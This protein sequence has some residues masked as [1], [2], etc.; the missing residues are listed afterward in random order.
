MQKVN[1]TSN[2]RS[3]RDVAHTVV[4]AQK[5]ISRMSLAKDLWPSEHAMIKAGIMSENGGFLVTDWLEIT[6]TLTNMK[7]SAAECFRS[8]DRRKELR[9]LG[10]LIQLQQPANI[11]L[12]ELKKIDNQ[13][14]AVFDAVVNDVF[15]AAEY[16]GNVFSGETCS[17]IW[18]VKNLK[19][20]VTDKERNL[21]RLM[22]ETSQATFGFSVEEISLDDGSA[23]LTEKLK[24][25]EK[26][27]GQVNGLQMQVLKL[28]SELFEILD[29]Q[30]RR[31]SND[32]TT[33]SLLPA[34]PAGSAPIHLCIMMNLK[35]T[36]IKIIERYYNSPEL[37]SCPVLNDLDAWR[38]KKAQN[39]WE[40]GLYTGESALH[41]AIVQEDADLVRY[42]LESGISLASRATGLFF[43]PK[44]VPRRVSGA[45]RSEPCPAGTAEE[46]L[47]KNDFSACY[48][49]EFPLSFGASVG[50]CEICEALYQ[51]MRRRLDAHRAE[52]GAAGAR[53]VGPEAAAR[54]GGV[55][56]GADVACFGDMRGFLNAA[57]SLGN[58]AMHLAA[59]H[60]RRGVIDWFSS[61][62]GG[63]E[64]LEALNWE[65]LTPLTLAARYGHVATYQ[66]IL[67]TC[68]ST[69]VWVFGRVRLR[70]TDLLQVDTHRVRGAAL[71][72]SPRWRSVLEIA[73][74]YELE[75]LADDALLNKLVQSKWAAFGR[76]AYM[77]QVFLPYA[78]LLACFAAVAANPGTGLSDSESL[79]AA[80]ECVNLKIENNHTAF[81]SGSILAFLG[82]FALAG[83]GAAA[84]AEATRWLLY[85]CGPAWLVNKSW[86][87]GW[88]R[89]TAKDLDRDGD[90]SVSWGEVADFLLSHAEG[91]LDLAAATLLA[92]AALARAGG[93]GRAEADCLACASVALFLNLLHVLAPFR[94]FGGLTVTVHK[95]LRG[96]VSR[97]MVLYLAM[98]T[99]FAFGRRLLLLRTDGQVGPADAGLLHDLFS[100]FWVRSR[101][102]PRP[103]RRSCAALAC[104]E[105]LWADVRFRAWTSDATL[106]YRLLTA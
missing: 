63:R 41:M 53:P 7:K 6:E 35:K 27:S 49:G 82:K 106:A 69:T 80:G 8:S 48:Y 19:Q 16:K 98:H 66:H 84:V 12:G 75:A 61:K 105:S 38:I 1:L 57:D 30:L 100:P 32:M 104:L 68:L 21:R 94:F 58:T 90:G 44:M 2:N 31:L 99:G 36:G 10:N 29:Y 103:W 79:P 46:A 101:R 51:A 14:K 50:S 73:V 45:D 83:K 56:P 39:P 5:A 47:V 77:R 25:I 3:F 42:L 102:V 11:K 34:G 95:M 22:Q 23:L 20:L 87:H 74:A 13:L 89:A 81:E 54:P 18:P 76:R 64:A 9:Q 4:I 70:Q 67:H 93:S 97:F 72:A 65:G 78:A 55:G 37:L 86:R 40:D 17:K 24:Q 28:E 71:H 33:Y 92:G 60:D 88:L 15:N 43:Q 85:C 62:E 26:W 96:D 59:M 91:V 52:E